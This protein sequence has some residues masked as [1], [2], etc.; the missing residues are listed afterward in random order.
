MLRRGAAASGGR[1]LVKPRNQW[2]V[3]ELID[4][5]VAVPSNP[6]VLD[7][8]LQ[9]LTPA[10]RQVLALIGHSRQPCWN[11]GN[12]VEMAIALGQT[13]GLQPVFDLLEAGLLYPRLHGAEGEPGRNGGTSRKI[14]SFEQWLAAPGPAGLRCSRRRRSPSAPSA[15]TSACPI[16]P[17][18]SERPA[19]AG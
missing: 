2:P 1:T 12:L 19:S 13:D 18:A 9:D 5:G 10:A 7:R 3:E 14:K 4:R 17:R 6:V 16:S 15:K 8:R 11:L